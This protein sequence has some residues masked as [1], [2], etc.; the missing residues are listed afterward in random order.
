MRCLIFSLYLKTFDEILLHFSRSTW[1][2]FVF[3][4]FRSKSRGHY[5]SG[6]WRRTS[7]QE[8][9]TICCEDYAPT[10]SQGS[11]FTWKE[12]GTLGK[13]LKTR[14]NNMYLLTEWEDRT[15][16]IWVEVRTSGGCLSEIALWFICDS[17]GIQLSLFSHSF[18]YN[19]FRDQYMGFNDSNRPTS[20]L[21]FFPTLSFAHSL[22]PLGEWCR[23]VVRSRQWDRDIMVKENR[24]KSARRRLSRIPE[25]WVLFLIKLK[26]LFTPSW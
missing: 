25:M 9:N 1:R 12:T 20:G 16:N 13:K 5:I 26:L 19:F 14:F 24:N 3:P 8:P 18:S 2:E 10:G 23:E 11:L 4:Y 15:G 22:P 21:S 17:A 7:L 6:A